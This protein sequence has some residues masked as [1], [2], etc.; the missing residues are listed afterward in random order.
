MSIASTDGMLRQS[1]TKSTLR[2]FLITKVP[3]AI[4]LDAPEKA[5][6]IFDGFSLYHQFKPRETYKEWFKC[7]LLS[8]MPSEALNPIQIEI[9]NDFYGERSVK[10]DLRY[11]DQCMK[12][13][14]QSYHQKMPQG[15]EWKKFFTNSENK[16]NL[17]RLALEFFKSLEGRLLLRVPLIFTCAE[18]RYE[19]SQDGVEVLQFC[20]HFE[21]DTKVIFQAATDDTPV[22]VVAKDT[23]TFVL[24]TFSFYKLCPA[25]PWFMCYKPDHYIDIQKI[26]KFIGPDISSVFPQI[27]A[28]SGCD[29]TAYKY[30][31]SKVTLLKKL[32]REKHLC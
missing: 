23:D 24:I 32:I 13:H 22:V 29:T 3:E 16:N 31:T 6:W 27:H 20:N 5:R 21:A 12:Y 18:K 14:L 11:T 26:A 28:I 17:V 9:V 7:I 25:N 4:N 2:H 15:R 1:S 30:G 19:I 10:A 8:I